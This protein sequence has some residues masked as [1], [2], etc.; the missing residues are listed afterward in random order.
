[1]NPEKLYFA[2]N[3]NHKGGDRWH[4]T[5]YGK[6]FSRNGSQNLRFGE[7]IIEPDKN[8]VKSSLDKGEGESLA[9]YLTELAKEASITAYKDP[10]T[11]Q[12]KKSWSQ[13]EPSRMLF[14]ALKTE[15]MQAADV[16]IYIHGFNVAWEQAVGAALALQYMLNRKRKGA[17]KQTLVVLFSWPSDGSMVPYLAYG[18]DRADAKASGLAI[19]RAMLKLR[20]FLRTL[21]RGAEHEDEE[22]CHQDIHLLCKSMGNYV[23]QHALNKLIENA[24]GPA[25]PRIF[26]H[27]FLCAPDVAENVL[28]AGQPMGRL[29][30]LGRN[31]TAYFNTG[32][33]AMYVSDYTKGNSER[34]GHSGNAHPSLV[35]RK[36]HQV[37][38]SPIVEGLTE[39]SYY[40]WSTVNDDIQLSI[41]GAD[42]DDE[43]RRRR[44]HGHSNEWV[45]PKP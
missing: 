18:S 19:G 38:C 30:E 42:V 29:H 17:E 26:K 5:R 15:M 6:R 31:I 45:L 39:H 14:K 40:L 33:L 11:P 32:D 13:E 35:H 7:L 37:D 43:A 22:L 20:D 1:M 44:R 12:E 10:T 2:T 4:P 16:L 21:R 28:E 27:I 34:V 25:L 3:R 9:S 8:D 36:I 24:E 23:L 41:E